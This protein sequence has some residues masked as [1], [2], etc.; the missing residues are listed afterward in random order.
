MT[1]QKI[2]K[3]IAAIIGVAGIVLWIF[4]LGSTE[5][6]ADIMINVAKV[7]V[8]AAA[9]IVLLFT[10]I[11]LISHPDKLKKSLLAIVSFLVIVAIG[12]VLADGADINMQDMAKRGISITE[13]TSKLVG[14]GLITFYILA[15]LAA[16]MMLFTGIA[17]FLKK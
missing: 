17:K 11:N 5:P 16:G 4:L 10:L 14:A 13:S 12:Y 1:I 6:Y 3:L 15:I 8:V 9:A 7:L 2:T